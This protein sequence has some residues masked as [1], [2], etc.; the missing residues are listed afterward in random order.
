[1]TQLQLPEPPNDRELRIAAA[2][3]LLE[4]FLASLSPRTRRAYDGDI[5]DFSRFLAADSSRA[6]IERF[7]SA[8]PTNANRLALDYRTNLVERGLA[9]ATIA[10]RLSALRSIVEMGARF[11]G[12]NWSL[13]IKSPKVE[14]YRDT[15][16]PGRDGWRRMVE[17]ARSRLASPSGDGARAVR[18][19]AI[20][21]L[22]HD[23]ML[24]RSEVVGLDVAQ[25][26]EGDGR[27][28]AAWVLGKGRADRQRLELP[29]I[30]GDAL[31][32]WLAIRG[33]GP[34][35]LFTRIGRASMTPGAAPRRLSGWSV[36]SIVRDLG[37]TAA[38]PR[39]VHPHGLRHEGI[40]RA[41]EVGSG[42]MGTMKAARH[43]DSRTTQRYIDRYED[44]TAR[45]HRQI[46]ED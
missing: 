15:T 4:S 44:P 8:G 29:P 31:K 33:R 26:E 45:I 28:T 46:S 35:P 14:S 16:G 40:T 13:K 11:G 18:D 21:R 37:E 7:L 39:S 22:L 30:T 25:I 1:M 41:I 23:L 42:L 43:R 36:W 3:D 9:P 10:R 20:V 24:R 12:V 2:Q 19:L 32:A 34:G 5:R 17:A 38:L 27:P 6:A